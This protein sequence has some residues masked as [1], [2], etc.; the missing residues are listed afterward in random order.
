VVAVGSMTLWLGV[1][2]LVNV[3]RL[4]DPSGPDR[5]QRKS[6]RKRSA[7]KGRTFPHEAETKREWVSICRISGWPSTMSSCQLI[8]VT[9]TSRP[10]ARSSFQ[11]SWYSSKGASQRIT[12]LYSVE[13]R[14]SDRVWQLTAPSG[15]ESSPDSAFFRIRSN[16]G[17]R[18]QRV[19]T[20]PLP[21]LIP[22][23]FMRLITSGGNTSSDCLILSFCCSTRPDS[24]R[25]WKRVS[26]SPGLKS[27]ANTL[28]LNKP[29]NQKTV[30]TGRMLPSQVILM[31]RIVPVKAAV[32]RCSSPL[33][34]PRR[35]AS[36]AHRAAARAH[37][38]RSRG[39]RPCR[40]CGS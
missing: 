15:I 20:K 34:S 10:V 25:S 40:P 38:R 7:D 17:A 24:L 29:I 35:C 39:R 21:Q 8:D 12:R 4:L 6:F 9:L 28:V 2:H 32:V 19:R 5:A 26:H 1:L 36:R 23:A 16:S 3:C 11:T 31:G 14:D 33:P 27:V 13:V 37:C 18:H 22:T 30:R